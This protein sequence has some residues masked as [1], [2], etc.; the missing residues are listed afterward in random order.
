MWSYNGNKR[1]QV[2]NDSN[3]NYEWSFGVGN[4]QNPQ[5]VAVSPTG[6]IYVTDVAFGQVVKYFDPTEWVSGTPHFGAEG[7][8]VG[9]G[10]ILGTSV[11]L[12]GG[13]NL[14][15]DGT[16]TIQSGGTLTQTIAFAQAASLTNN[17]QYTINGSNVTASGG[18]TNN[19]TM[20]MNGGQVQGNVTNN[21]V[22][23]PQRH[24]RRPG[25][26]RQ[27]GHALAKR[28]TLRRVLYELDAP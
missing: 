22:R 13:K 1:V 23:H 15:V 10:Q 5:F 14:T 8:A 9:P 7:A 18:V 27:S 2:L 12:A 11:N 19:A 28:H 24:G 4:L 21:Y 16:L 26:P 25:H 17:G 20:T 3:G 6:E